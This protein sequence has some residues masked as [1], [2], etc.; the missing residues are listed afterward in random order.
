MRGDRRAA[1]GLAGWAPITLLAGLALASLL[2]LWRAGGAAGGDLSGL[3]GHLL[4]VT[5]GA[6]RQAALSALL[7]ALLGLGMALS[8]TRM[9]DGAGRRAILAGLTVATTA[10]AII[11]V[12]G[13]VS[14]FG[15]SGW[16][17]ALSGLVGLPPPPAIYGL[18]GIV[19]AH[20]AMNAPFMAR[21]LLD[22]F[23]RQPGERLRLAAALGFGPA[24]MFRHVDAPV[25]RRELPGLAALAFLLCF[26]SFAVVLAL[27]GGPANATLEVA[28]YQAL[29]VE[30]DFARAAALAFLQFGIGL[31]FVMLI[32]AGMRRV[33]EQAAAERR[34]E[35]PD[36]A[37]GWLRQ[38]DRAAL[39]LGLLVCLPPMLATL[40]ALPQLPALIEAEVARATLTSLAVAFAAG[41]LAVLLAVWLALVARPSDYGPG[42]PG[43]SRAAEFAV[44]GFIGL[45]PFA[46]V[47]GLYVL[48][49]GMADPALLSLALLP[50]VNALMALP[51]AYRLVQPPLALAAERH[52]R[53]AAALGLKGID[54]MRV[55]DGPALRRPALAAFALAA[56]FSLG[57]YGVIALFGSA[58]FQTLPALLSSRLGAYRLEEAG[59]VG[60]LI[61]L[62][63]AAL[64]ALADRL[65]RMGGRSAC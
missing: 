63:V 6:A 49:R 59:A 30:A 39:A 20:V 61:L 42:R 51:F 50:V 1:S 41:A 64:A 40:A 62:L 54:R 36:A 11:I 27:G 5:F 31:G 52:G 45:P 16:L 44:L 25:I 14:L 19:L 26:T 18:H 46:F 38:A 9:G 37:V 43:R 13:L 57:D 2:G 23:E 28:V 32:G 56:A 53:V 60:L 10:P 47:T 17:A 22:A 58:E 33:P 29:R 65:G 12:F 15:R 35:R 4:G 55:L 3:A 24:A 7:S 34:A 48:A 8:L 21:A